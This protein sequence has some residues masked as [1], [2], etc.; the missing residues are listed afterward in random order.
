MTVE[1]LAARHNQ[2]SVDD[3]KP[4]VGLTV[5]VTCKV[6]TAVLFWGLK[7]ADVEALSPAEF[8]ELCRLTGQT[9]RELEQE[10]HLDLKHDAYFDDMRDYMED[11]Y[12]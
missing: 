7:Q 12:V 5:Q 11:E 9:P 1:E 10:G 3:G 2:H 4:A 8:N 6:E